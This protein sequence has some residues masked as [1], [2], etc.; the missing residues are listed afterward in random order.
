MIDLY[1]QNTALEYINKNLRKQLKEFESGERYLKVQENYRKINSGYVRRIHQLEKEL[2]AEKNRVV[3]VRNLWFKLCENILKDSE[4]TYKKYEKEIEKLNDIIQKL[5]QKYDDR[6]AKLNEDHKTETDEK[7]AIIKTLSEEVERLTAKQSRNSSNTSLPTSKTPIDQKKLIPNSRRSSGKP[8]GGQFGHE[9]HQLNDPLPEE[10]NEKVFLGLDDDSVCPY[11]DSYEF[12][13]T[14]ESEK[15]YEY[16]VKITTIKR[17]INYGKYKC[18]HCGNLVRAAILPNNQT[19]SS[20]GSAVQAL[21]LSLGNTVNAPLNKTAMIFSGITDGEICPSEAYISNLQ[22][23]AAKKLAPFMDDLYHH[24]I[25]LPLVYWDDTVIMVDKK[26]ACLRFYGNDNAAYY[27]AHEDKT[28]NG[29]LEDGILSALPKEAT[30]M[31]DHCNI[32]YNDQFVFENVEC[33]AHLLRDLQKNYEDTKHKELMDI[34]NLISKT[35]KDRNDLCEKGKE[36]FDDK[37]ISRFNKKLTELLEKVKVKADANESK[38]FGVNERRLVYRIIKFR[39][40]Y[41]AWVNDFRLPHTNNLSERALRGVKGKLKVAGQFSSV[42]TAE[43]YA[44]IRSYIETC[45][46]NSINE[47][48]ALKRLC[49]GNPYTVA[50]IFSYS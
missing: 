26:R 24:L 4:R 17:E 37:Y 18:K 49:N 5:I 11:C 46:R 9:K 14:G 31:H 41:F 29:V 16:D 10:I 45:R 38:Y 1:E 19:S 25:A 3:S 8:K 7:D 2:A 36:G 35:V 32:S 30:V 44:V 34:K 23:K 47:I 27:V 39:E 20:Y 48:E 12:I 43:N 28:L 42:N 13:Y 33:N 15:K 50:E 6:I 40:N 21:A 22:K